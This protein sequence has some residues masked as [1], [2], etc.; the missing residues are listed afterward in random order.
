MRPALEALVWIAAAFASVSL[1]VL[2]F[3]VCCALARSRVVARRRLSGSNEPISVVIPV[4]LL[5]AG[6]AQAQRSILAS[7][8]AG[9]EIIVTAREA[10][11]P[12][13]TA[14][15]MAFAD[16]SVPVRFMQ[17]TAAFAASP[18]I[19][20][21]A[22]AFAAAKH[23]VIFMKDSN[24]ELRGGVTPALAVLHGDVGLVC[25]IPRASEAE[26]FAAAVEAQV[27]NQSHGRL[28]LMADAL[29]LGFGVG[30]I[31]VFRKSSLA[32]IGGIEAIAS[33]VGEDAALSTALARVGL[34]TVFMAPFV[35]QRLGA[36]SWRDV[37]DR[38]MRW[39]AVRA[40]D[41]KVPF[42][43]EPLGLCV[44]VAVAAAGAAPLVGMS[45]V[46][47][48][49]LTLAFWFACE[50]ALA[51][52]VGW[53]VALSAP[54]VMVARDSL[55]LAVWIKA[56]FTRRVVWAGARV[57]VHRVADGVPA[58]PSVLLHRERRTPT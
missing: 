18:K 33:S 37:F 8:P 4:K 26:T 5:D 22:E 53:P 48:A 11:S 25:A 55:M 46:V 52:A 21:L 23:D 49:L 50:T 56:W 36:R 47:A 19:D 13:L 10:S 57:D 29:G 3:S 30:K 41:A 31:M 6:F 24:V 12:A 20:N 42:A 40:H 32:K 15:Q 58:M 51:L 27:M 54:A 34:R 7:L 35:T 1:T 44:L 39:T 14:A 38:Q 9:S 2:A 43:L 17:S 45:P 28:L 16:T